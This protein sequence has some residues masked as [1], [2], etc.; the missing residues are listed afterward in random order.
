M[1]I[2]INIYRINTNIDY[3]IF[4]YTKIYSK[5]M[6]NVYFSFHVDVNL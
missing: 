4:K 3:F 5:K 1:D 2:Y 6:K